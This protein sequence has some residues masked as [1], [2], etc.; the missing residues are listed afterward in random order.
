LGTDS[1]VHARSACRFPATSR[2]A[3][4]RSHGI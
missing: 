2:I 1:S 3:Q 4:R